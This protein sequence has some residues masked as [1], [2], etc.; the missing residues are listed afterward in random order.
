MSF[1]IRKAALALALG[2]LVVVFAGCGKRPP[3][4]GDVSGKVTVG[5]KPVTAGVVKFFPDAGEPVE[6]SLGPDGAYRATG[7]PAGRSKV[8]IETLQFKNLTQPPPA[9]AKQLG[10]PRA[11][12]VPIPAKYEKPDTSG[13]SV[14]VRDGKV[15]TL[16]VEMP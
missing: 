2:G 8:A 9:I 13:L 11:K 7:V 5:G 3:P 15:T 4:A 1:R 14:D 6:T 10:G 12:Y 16:D